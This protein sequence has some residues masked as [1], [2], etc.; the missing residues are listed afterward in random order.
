MADPL[1]HAAITREPEAP[2]FDVRGMFDRGLA[3]L[4]RLAG[5]G[6]SDHN[7]HD[8]GITILELACYALTE[9]AYR[10]SWPVEDLVATRDGGVA[11]QFFRC[12]DIL[13]NGPLTTQDWRRLLIDVDGVRNAWIEPDDSA[14]FH[15]DLEQHR[16]ALAPP[17]HGKSRS[18]RLRGLHRVRIDFAPGYD[19]PEKR[20]QTLAKVRATLECH[21]NLCQ[22]FTRICKVR[23]EF[24]SVC[25]EFELDDDAPVA[26]V[27]V[28]ILAAL[29]DLLS[30]TIPRYSLAEMLE[31]RDADDRPLGV[32]RIFEG[33]LLEHGFI[34]DED[35]AASALPS[36]IRL[37]DL[38]GALMDVPGVRHVTDLQLHP[39]DKDDQSV[40][41][42]NP[43][44]VPVSPAHLPRLSRIAGRLVFTK[45][46][47]AVGAWQMSDMPDTVRTRLDAWRRHAQAARETP[48]SDD[49][50]APP[51]RVRDVAEYISFQRD[52]PALYRLGPGQLPDPV[53]DP[54]SARIPADADPR[55]R[56]AILQL[57]AFL[58]FFDQVLAG[59][60]ETLAAARRWLS[61]RPADLRSA[62]PD[63]DEHHPSA[64]SAAW[65][66]TID[67]HGLLHATGSPPP[68]P[69]V[70][71]AE[72]AKR[73]NRFLDHLLARVAEDFASYAA[74]MDSA[75]STGGAQL[76]ADK[77]RFLAEVALLGGQ[78][79]LACARI[80]DGP[81][82]AP[83][84]TADR[85]SGIERR[86]CRLLG[87]VDRAA[88]GQVSV[89]EEI[90]FE[91]DDTPGDE[92]RFRVRHHATGKILL[93]SSTRYTTHEEARAELAVVLERA[94]MPDG[95]QRLTTID[96]RFY[97]NIVAADGSVVARRIEY[98]QTEGAM[99]AAILETMT[100]LRGRHSN[101]RL[102]V[103]EHLQLRPTRA[104]DPLWEPLCL[105]ASCEDCSDDPYSHRLHVVL[106]AEAGRF[107]NMEFRRF[108]EATIRRELPAHLLPT[109]CWLDA[110]RMEAL[111][112]AHHA[113]AE[114]HDGAD[115][116]DRAARIGA[117]IEALTSGANAYPM[118][119]ISECTGEDPVPHFILGRT[120]LGDAGAG[121]PGPD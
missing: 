69:P 109:V 88:H 23:E 5:D 7:V 41:V 29:E 111:E 63:P 6:W 105:D 36:E 45:G 16:L 50:P 61:V 97:F 107:R 71:A 94:Q 100:Y 93:S 102:Y 13:P 59:Q 72:A 119:P 70:L 65:T 56:A 115:V 31:R 112:K 110:A 12:R 24:F 101:E 32:D 51:G 121:A 82:D 68:P 57:K 91:N 60:R 25:G 55:Q 76:A 42:A 83:V 30:P 52:F 81:R 1:P 49:L 26:D 90:Y 99:E 34:A 19:T 116:A 113:W 44:R 95:Y 75:F 47:L 37:S 89:P 120:A 18:F 92:P 21:R 20:D 62:T 40:P 33:P 104:D 14:E 38:I 103:I 43:W 106:P 58:L 98:F 11:D 86:L 39:L 96:H 77:R 2:A 53:P 54:P 28:R 4:R 64:L 48:R 79:A 117:L 80:D 67:G 8:P 118:Q 15:V 66:A 10:S 85:I 114:L 46:G 3:T 27:A 74:I 9:N 87:I 35:L 22:E 78:R 73:R 108:V 84:R 17:A